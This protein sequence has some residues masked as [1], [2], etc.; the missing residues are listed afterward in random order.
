MR[1]NIWMKF[2]KE[3]WGRVSLYYYKCVGVWRGEGVVVV[4]WNA[5]ATWTQN[6]NFPDEQSVADNQ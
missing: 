3:G 6:K 5:L 2:S 1:K 4:A